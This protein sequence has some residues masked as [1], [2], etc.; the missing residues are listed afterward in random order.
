MSDAVKTYITAISAALFLVVG[1]SGLAVFFGIGEDLVKGMHEWLA[2]IF[3]LA[4]G[5]H[6]VRNWGGMKTYFRRG[7]IVTPLV[8][9]LIAATAFI[10][11][12]ALSGRTD[13]MP[14]L[15]HSLENAKLADL[16]RVLDV[17]A[18]SLAATLEDQGFVVGSLDQS[19]SE[20]A[21]DSNQPPMAALMTVLNAKR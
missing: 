17:P 21:Q 19:L 4:I 18:D 8:A 20:I 3:V 14:A 2:V 6:L 12:A 13:P 7:T 1:A 10:V 15:F 11:P 9:V 5:L 16:G